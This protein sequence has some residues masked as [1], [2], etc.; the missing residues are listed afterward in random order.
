MTNDELQREAD[1]RNIE[2]AFTQKADDDN[3]PRNWDYWVVRNGELVT[4]K[5][6]QISDEMVRRTNNVI[7][8]QR[9]ITSLPQFA[10]GVPIA[11]ILTRAGLTVREA[12]AKAVAEP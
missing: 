4:R 3:D 10:E 12:F 7:R 9:F 1:S 8:L 2:S 5:G 6:I 11:E